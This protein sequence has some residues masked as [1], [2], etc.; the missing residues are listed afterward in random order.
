LP[1]WRSVSLESAL[2][3]CV[4]HRVD[5]DP[6]NFPRRHIFSRRLQFR[7]APNPSVTSRDEFSGETI[8]ALEVV[9]LP[10]RFTKF[11]SKAQ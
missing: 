8:S 1:S 9:L 4:A 3:Y 7:Q 5:P 2:W 10:E 6:T 11:Y